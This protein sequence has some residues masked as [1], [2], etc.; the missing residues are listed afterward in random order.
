MD[1]PAI[2]Y[3]VDEGCKTLR[4]TWLKSLLPKKRAKANWV[5][6]SIQLITKR[7]RHM[8][9]VVLEQRNPILRRKRALIGILNDPLQ[10]ISP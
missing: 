1:I 5:G 10:N 4:A 7:R 6:G 2:F 8:K 3:E 9:P